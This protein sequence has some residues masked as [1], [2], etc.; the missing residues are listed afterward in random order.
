MRDFLDHSKHMKA[1]ELSRQG[2]RGYLQVRQQIGATPAV[3]VELAELQGS[4]QGLLGGIEE[5]QALDAG[6]GTDARLTQSLQIAFARAGV[7]ETGQER[8]VAL[9]AAEQ[10]FTQIDQAIDCLLYT[11][12]AFVPVQ[13]QIHRSIP[14]HG[15][16]QPLDPWRKLLCLLTG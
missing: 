14:V 15:R 8:Q 2:R 5:V 10:D 6:I 11:S 16:M 9:I 3:D 4:Q 1:F 13:R 7:V 12:P